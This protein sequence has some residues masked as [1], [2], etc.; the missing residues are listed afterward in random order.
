MAF[1]RVPQWEV[2]AKGVDVAA[3]FAFASQ[4]SAVFQV[5][6]DALDRALGD[7]HLVCNIPHPRLGLP[8]QA[9]QDVRVIGQERPADVDHG[10]GYWRGG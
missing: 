4:V 7:P 2:R 5:R 8:R 9:D 10:R 1:Q 6:H 3:P